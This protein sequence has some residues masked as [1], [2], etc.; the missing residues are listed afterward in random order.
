[1]DLCLYP[2]KGS[3][4][5]L[6][7]APYTEINIILCLEGVDPFELDDIPTYDGVDHPAD[8]VKR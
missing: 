1:M 5:S 6:L 7:L 4:I 2:K 3:R 8:S